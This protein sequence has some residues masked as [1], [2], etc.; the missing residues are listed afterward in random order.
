MA[1]ARLHELRGDAQA[2]ARAAQAA[3]QNVF[4]VELLAHLR[5]GDRL[6][7]ERQHRR[8]REHSQLA[9]LGKLGDDVFRHAVAEVLI[10]FVP[11]QVFE[12]HHRDGLLARCN[13]GRHAPGVH[14]ALQALEVSAELGRRL[15]AYPPVL[16]ERL[17]DNLRQPR[18]DVAVQVLGRRGRAVQD[19]IENHRGRLAGKRRL[20]GGHLVEHHP[21]GE[22]VRARVHVLTARL[23][24]RHISHG[25]QRRAGLVANSSPR[26]L[27]GMPEALTGSPAR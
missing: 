19:G 5:A 21:E 3:A 20:A 16:F 22:Q 23:L 27:V 18:R 7:A 14:L 10:F 2:V 4:G 13:A 8:P 11:A 9:D 24:R 12:I 25:A 15:V 6:V 17:A 26:A 1:R